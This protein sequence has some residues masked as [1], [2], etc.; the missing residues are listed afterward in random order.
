V[1]CVNYDNINITQTSRVSDHYLTIEPLLT[2]DAGNI[3]S[4][5]EN[6]LPLDYAPSS[7]VF[8]EYSNDTAIQQV[9]HVEGQHHFA[10]LTVSLGEDIAIL[11]GTDLRG[12]SDVTTPG[13]HPNLDVS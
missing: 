5:E 9:I 4:R 11:D 3:N 6:Y 13:S 10:R 1:R 2:L 12:L 7:F 8:A